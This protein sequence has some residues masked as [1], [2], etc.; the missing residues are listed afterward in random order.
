MKE[1][2]EYRALLIELVKRDIKKKYRRSV[3]GGGVLRDRRRADRVRQARG[4]HE[5][6][7]DRRAVPLEA[8]ELGPRLV[9]DLVGDLLGLGDRRRARRDGDVERAV[10]MVGRQR[11][12]QL[13]RGGLEG[14]GVHDPLGHGLG[15][16]DGHDGV[17]LLVGQL[18]GGEVGAGVVL[19]L[20]GDVDPHVR[21]RRDRVVHGRHEGHAQGQQGA[22]QHTQ[23]QG[24]DPL[25]SQ[26]EEILKS[27][28]H[29]TDQDSG[30]GEAAPSRNGRFRG[31][32]HKAC[33]A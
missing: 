24:D 27:H 25:T 33:E 28:L 10:L 19:P 3:L 26:R 14:Q 8:L 2:F 12:G 9:D 1:I 32:T 29:I 18:G 15:G 6:D 17:D 23:H 21:H 5:H 4:G 11:P 30:L 7:V 13:G 16:E 22:G 31:Y 20:G